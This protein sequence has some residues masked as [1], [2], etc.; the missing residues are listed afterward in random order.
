MSRPLAPAGSLRGPTSTKSL[1]MTLR[2]WQ[3]EALGDELVLGHRVVHA[4][5][6]RRHRGVRCP[7]PGRCRGRRPGR[8][9]RWHCVYCGSRWP[10]RPDCSVEVVDATTMNG[11]WAATGDRPAAT[12]ARQAQNRRSRD[13]AGSAGR[14]TAR[15]ILPRTRP[16]WRYVRACIGLRRQSPQVAVAAG[17]GAALY[18]RQCLRPGRPSGRRCARCPRTAAPCPRRRRSWPARWATAGGAWST[19]GAWPATC[20]ADVHQPQEQLQRIQEASAGFASAPGALFKPKVIS[21]RP[22]PTGTCRP[23]RGRGGRSSPA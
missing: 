17:A 14:S 1:Y 22:C 13:M 4:A 21:P 15:P 2:R 8:R 23:A 3:A 7:G 9:R 16:R 20:V 12:R 19:P 10:N 5:R 11:G 6:R 18:R